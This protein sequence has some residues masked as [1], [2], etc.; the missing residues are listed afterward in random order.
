MGPGAQKPPPGPKTTKKKQKKKLTEPSQAVKT[1]AR[2]TNKKLTAAW[3]IDGLGAS[4]S[5]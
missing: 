3:V 5:A 2:Q 1:K 4:P